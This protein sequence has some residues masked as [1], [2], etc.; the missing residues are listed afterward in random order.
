LGDLLR[1]GVGF[2]ARGFICFWKNGNKES[3]GDMMGMLTRALFDHL[4]EIAWALFLIFLFLACL[5]M[6]FGR[7]LG[8]DSVLWV[9]LGFALIVLGL[10]TMII[11]GELLWI[12]F[13]KVLRRFFPEGE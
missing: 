3:M 2:P 4:K 11:V 7:E 6:I 13:W 9:C 10:F 1:Q 12:V 5:L 8:F